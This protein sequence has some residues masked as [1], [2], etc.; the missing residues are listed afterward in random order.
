MQTNSTIT[1]DLIS[2]KS[3]LAH[4]VAQIIEGV[5]ANLCPNFI[6]F[7]EK[8]PNQRCSNVM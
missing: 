7:I 5:K 6:F 1:I 2:E 3:Q 4:W 8:R